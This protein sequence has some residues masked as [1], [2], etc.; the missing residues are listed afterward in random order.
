MQNGGYA[1]TL[2]THLKY[3]YCCPTLIS[4]FDIFIYFG[5]FA[6]LIWILSAI[7]PTWKI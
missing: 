5:I 1:N 2:F 3:F 7:H 6:S 4:P